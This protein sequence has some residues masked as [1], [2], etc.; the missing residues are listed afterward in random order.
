[1]EELYCNRVKEILKKKGRVSAAWLHMASNV[2]AEILAN[3]GFDVLV[4]DVEHSPVDY[5]TVFSMC[6]AMKGTNTVPFARAP[7]NDLIAI[8]RICDCGVMGIHIPYVR[9]VDEAR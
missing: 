9:T 1:M 3:A 6:Q 5:Q 2:S 7:W 8:K 4:I